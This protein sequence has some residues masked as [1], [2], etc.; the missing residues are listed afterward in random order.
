LE[1]TVGKGIERYLASAAFAACKEGTK[2]NIRRRADVLRDRLGPALLADLDTDG[3]DI[4]TEELAKEF[5]ASVADAHVDL[6]SGIWKACRKYPEFKLK[7]KPNPTIEAERRYHVKRPH[8]PWPDDV[9]ALFMKTAPARL[10]LAKLLL[11]FSAQRGGDCIKMLWAD[12][13]GKGLWVRPEKI[14]GKP[15]PLPDYHHRPAPLLDALNAAPREAKTIL[16]TS[17]GKPYA[18]ASCLAMAIRRHLKGIGVYTK[19]R[20]F[21]MHGLRKNAASEVGALLVG[22]A[23]IRSVT[24]HR[25][26]SMADY[27]AQ[28]ASRTA[29]NAAVV[30]RWNEALTTGGRRTK[31]PRKSASSG[32]I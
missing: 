19:D 16:V 14:D 3:I 26:N 10:K 18:R 13:D 5:G 21:S 22:T 6:L 17:F 15:D 23:G 20:R 9:Q 11:H 12:F 2:S 8:Q 32:T 7:G 30:E 28:H 4:Y 25:S 29:M 31:R 1:G 24:G 27:Y